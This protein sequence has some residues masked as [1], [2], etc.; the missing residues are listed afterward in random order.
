MDSD[1]FLQ[2]CEWFSKQTAA[3]RGC[4]C[5]TVSTVDGYGAPETFR[6]LHLLPKENIVVIALPT[7]S[8]RRTQVLDFSI[9]SL[10]NTK[11]RN[12]LNERAK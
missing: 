10:F 5:N 9:F 6:C 2:F 1:G 3:Q 8:S 12:A 4:H 11:L 7:D